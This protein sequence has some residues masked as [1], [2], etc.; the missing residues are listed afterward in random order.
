MAD[1]SKEKIISVNT[2]GATK[3]V[4]TLKQQIKELRDQLGMLEAGTAEYDAVAK[5]LADTNQR[6]IEV[7]E[8]MKYSNQDVGQ[9][10]S[11]LTRVATGVI[12][13][14]NGVNAVMSM[15][16]ADGEEAAEALRNIQLT[17]EVIQGMIAV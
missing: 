9:T 16:G 11:N 1:T 15:M 3:N 6:Q 4:K 17:M 5:Q 13:A 8:A 2:T 14:I 12:G 10:F 7:N